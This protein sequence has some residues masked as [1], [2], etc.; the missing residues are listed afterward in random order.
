MRRLTPLLLFVA[1]ALL[2]GATAAP[3]VGWGDNAEWQFAAWNAGLSHPTGYPLFLIVGWLW[4]H[5]LAL[6]GIAPARAMTLLSAL[7]GA[8][9]TAL[10]ATASDALLR[11]ARF[12]IAAGPRWAVATVSAIAFGLSPMHWA[13][14]QVAEVYSL[15]SALLLLLLTLLWR[16][17]RPWLIALTLGL[18]LGHHR[19]SWLWLPPL[20][21]WWALRRRADTSPL[22]SRRSVGFAALVALPQLL[23]LYLPWRGPRT[24]YLHQRLTDATQLTLYDGSFAAFMAQISGSQ[25]AGDLF[26][27]PISQQ[28]AILGQQAWLNVGILALTLALVALIEPQGLRS[29]DRLLLAGGLLLTLLFGL[30][31]SFGDVATMLIPAWIALWLL[32]ALALAWFMVQMR[33]H[34]RRAFFLIAALLLITQRLV[35]IPPSQGDQAAPRALVERLIAANPP[36]KAI[37]LSNDRDEMMPLWYAQFVEG[38]RRDLLF[39]F[40][41]LLPELTDIHETV[42]WAMEQQR[43]VLLSKEMRGLTTLWNIEEYDGGLWR[44]RGPAALP[45]EEPMQ[46]SLGGGITVLAWTPS[47]EVG[48]GEVT[49]DVLIQTT[50]PLPETLSFSLQ[51]FEN[52]R[53]ASGLERQPLGTKRAQDDIAPDPIFPPSHWPLNQPLLLKFRVEQPPMENA[54]IYV[55][56]LTSYINNE[57]EIIPVGENIVLGFDGRIE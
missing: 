34:S 28:A 22:L 37:I 4:S 49:I 19:I 36:E 5:A 14:A 39:A 26:N 13:Q 17:A 45:T 55:W 56:R 38:Q 50:D 53:D 18:L 11:R 27:A 3:D 32:A 2:Y 12:S 21:L 15:N 31:V 44:V 9:S 6:F 10:F 52:P 43:P 23:Y 20:A 47:M 24:A 25:F 7:F 35:S 29:S 16:G 57:G 46:K 51:F 30:S 41:L 1:F 40:P 42:T 48:A 33:G 8:A 54:I